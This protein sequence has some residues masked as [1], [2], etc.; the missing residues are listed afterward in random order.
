MTAAFSLLNQNVALGLLGLRV[1]DLNILCRHVSL[2][3]LGKKRRYYHCYTY[4]KLLFKTPSVLSNQAS[5]FVRSLQVF[6]QT[7]PPLQ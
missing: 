5:E 2:S 6:P 1:W 7:E 3:A 4:G